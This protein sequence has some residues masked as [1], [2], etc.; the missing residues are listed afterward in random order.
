[1][2]ISAQIIAS[3][4]S[5]NDLKMAYSILEDDQNMLSAGSE[6]I[7]KDPRSEPDNCKIPRKGEESVLVIN[8]LNSSERSHYNKAEIT[9]T[10]ANTSSMQYGLVP[11]FLNHRDNKRYE[12]II[13]AQI[14]RSQLRTP[15]P[16]TAL[17]QERENNELMASQVKLASSLEYKHKDLNTSGSIVLRNNYLYM[18]HSLLM[19]GKA[20]QKEFLSTQLCRPR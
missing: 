15:K 1:V 5:C 17:F 4:H 12:N 20:L 8:S 9:A 2:N 3:K 16:R 14:E 7:C 13:I 6:I 18:D 10:V 11:E 19:S